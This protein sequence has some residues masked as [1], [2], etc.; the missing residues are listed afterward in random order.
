MVCHASLRFQYSVSI[1]S[2]LLVQIIGILITFIYRDTLSQALKEGIYLSMEKYGMETESS[3]AIDLLQAEVRTSVATEC[4]YCVLFVRLGVVGCL[5]LWTGNTLAG[6]RDM[7]I[8]YLTHVAI[9]QLQVRIITAYA[10]AI[11]RPR[12]VKKQPYSC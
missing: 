10:G 6:G 3:Q 11:D 8:G 7:R 2:I 9:A 1:G 5:G 12:L 4:I